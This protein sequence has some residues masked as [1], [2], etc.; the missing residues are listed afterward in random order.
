MKGNDEAFPC[1]RSFRA[2]S[3][4]SQKAA[5]RAANWSSSALGSSG[6]GRSPTPT[7]QRLTNGASVLAGHS[8]FLGSRSPGLRQPSGMLLAEAVEAPKLVWDD[9]LQAPSV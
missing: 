3:S 2:T 6:S 8:A 9:H 4:S 1:R 7:P 5:V